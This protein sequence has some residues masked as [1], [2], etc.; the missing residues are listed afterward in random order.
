[1]YSSCVHSI[2]SFDYILDFCHS[3]LTYSLFHQL[4]VAPYGHVLYLDYSD[5]KISVTLSNLWNMA[6]NS[7]RSPLFIRIPCVVVCTILLTL[8]IF[9]FFPWYIA[10]MT[11][12]QLLTFMT[13]LILYGTLTCKWAYEYL[14]QRRCSLAFNYCTC[15]KSTHSDAQDAHVRNFHV[16]G[17][18]GTQITFTWDIVDGQHSSSYINGFSFFYRERNNPYNTI[19]LIGTTFDST[20]R[21][22]EGRT[23]SYTITFRDYTLSGPY[24]MWIRVNRRFSPLYYYSKQI[25]VL[26]GGKYVCKYAFVFVH[27][28]Q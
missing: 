28:E 1:M 2:F 22:N 27:L 6:V 16:S 15:Y 12:Q 11:A 4:Q 3:S 5:H 14:C 21:T 13:V 25:P 10:E 20:V 8:N 18:T 7:E 9:L 23:F 17:Q 26:F 19:A 24:V